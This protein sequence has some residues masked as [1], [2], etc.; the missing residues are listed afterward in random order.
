MEPEGS[1]PRSQ[2]LSIKKIIKTTK[3]NH[4]I[5]RNFYEELIHLMEEKNR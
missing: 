2:E 4:G 3:L 1:L 5:C